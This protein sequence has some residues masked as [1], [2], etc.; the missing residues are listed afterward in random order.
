VDVGY[1]YKARSSLRAA[2]AEFFADYV[3][4]DTP[5]VVPTPGVEVH[6]RYHDTHWV[7]VHGKRCSGWLRSS[8]ELH[9]KRLCAQGLK[10]IYQ[11]GPC[12]RAAED[13]PWH[14]LEFYMLEWYA[15]PMSYEELMYQTE[16]FLKHCFL[17]S[18]TRKLTEFTRLSVYECFEAFLGIQLVDCDPGLPSLLK[19]AGVFSITEAD[20]F[21]S[22]YYKAMLEVIEPRFASKSVL[23]YNYP[24]S[25][26]VL[27]HCVKGRA[28][29]VE[30]YIDGVEITNGCVELLGQKNNRLRLQAAKERRECLGYESPDLDEDFLKS[31]D[32]LPL[33]LCGSACGFDR[34]LALILGESSIRSLV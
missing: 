28:Q 30:G 15:A 11:L 25:Q 19:E 10:Q 17:S 24:P 1:Y 29:R 16:A 27:S 14:G 12:F 33:S 23:L 31:C 7:D 20:D 3:A 18:S 9:M 8:P 2:I 6:M 34:L 26:G 21:E 22:A 13:S 5:I 32:Q 4:V